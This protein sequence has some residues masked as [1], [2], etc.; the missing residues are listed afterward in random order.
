MAFY[1]VDDSILN[2]E[3][4]AAYFNGADRRIKVGI[5]AA[6]EMLGLPC[7][8]YARRA[9]PGRTPAK[10]VASAYVAD[11]PP[12]RSLHLAP[13]KQNATAERIAEIR[14]AK[15]AKFSNAAIPNLLDEAFPAADAD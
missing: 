1:N 8:D 13:R 14:A 11:N 6:I 15:A 7:P 3:Q 2:S 12:P 4:A 10:D 9:T 5:R